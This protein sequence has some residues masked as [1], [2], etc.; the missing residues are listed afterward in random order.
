MPGPFYFSYCGGPL[1]PAFSVLT[2]ADTWGGTVSTIGAVWGGELSTTGDVSDS[3]V[4]NL[5]TVDGLVD[6]ATYLVRGKGIPTSADGISADTF[7][8]Y[9]AGMGGGVLTQ[10]AATN[11]GVSLIL[12]SQD[13]RQQVPLASTDGLKGGGIYGITGSG[14]PAGTTFVFG[15]SSTVSIS[16]PAETTGLIPVKIDSTLDRDVLTNV[17]DVSA[18]TAGTQYDLFGQGIPSGASAVFEGGNTLVMSDNATQTV[19]GAQVLISKGA[20]YP[21]GGP[22]DE[23]QHLREDEQ[24]LAIDISQSEGDF[25]TCSL[26]VKNPRIGLLAP[27]RQL[28][29]WLSWDSGAGIVPLFHGRLVGVPADLENEAVRLQLLARP[30]DYQQQKLALAAS[31]QVAPYWDPVWIIEHANDPDTVLEAR[32]MLWHIDRTSLALTA[33]DV[34]DGEDGTVDIGEGDHL[35][36][37]LTVSYTGAPLRR[38]NVTATVTWVQSAVGDID[39]T[40]QIWQAFAAV[41]STFQYPIVC[42]FTGDGLQSAWPAARTNIGGGWSV[43]DDAAVETATWVKSGRYAVRYIDKSPEAKP[44]Q[45]KT[46]ST[47]AVVNA[48]GLASTDPKSFVT[49][50]ATQIPTAASVLAGYKAYDVLFDLYAFAFNFPVHYEA[51]RDRSEVLSFSLEAD[52][53][54]ILSEAGS[55]EAQALSFSSDFIS[56]PV[57]DSGLMPVRDLRRNAYFPTD[58]GQESVQYLLAVARAKLVAKARAVVIKFTVPWPLGVG[59]TLRQNVRLTDRR[60]PGGVA[61]GKISGYTLTARPDA[62][63]ACAVTINCMVGYGIALPPAETGE[64]AYIDDDY[65][66]GVQAR[67]GAQVDLLP[68]ELVYQSF[69]DLTVL[70]DDGVDLFN[71][72]PDAIIQSLYIL[73]GKAEQ[74]DAINAATG[75]LLTDDTNATTAGTSLTPMAALTLTPTRVTLELMPVTGGSFQ[76]NFYMQT[77]QLVLP[78]GINLEAPTNGT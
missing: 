25:A 23:A 76:S 28:W 11:I 60:L 36:E 54:S 26:D 12:T 49:Y 46:V 13:N 66:D 24:V 68:G 9:D 78:K 29:A 19:L 63:F 77:S 53:Q 27:T 69:D 75:L 18:L 8:I 43:G 37:S 52:V 41:G 35:Y 48:S 34:V 62:M 15:G 39:L 61:I 1:V 50:G 4:S 72:N 5:S 70:D 22:F 16:Q 14:I 33:S 51:A 17:Q 44:Q 64:G 6:G 3:I 40:T 71:L 73:G 57:D 20:T 56:Q 30:E 55:A 42:S 7:L 31:M 47:N 65:V 45:D 67:F 74:M 10:E 32:T 21:D 59:L 38:L 58:R 2:R